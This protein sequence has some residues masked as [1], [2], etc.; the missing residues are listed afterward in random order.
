MY[1]YN[2]IQAC[3]HFCGAKQDSGVIS[4]EKS[5]HFE[6]NKDIFKSYFQK[7]MDIY[8][9]KVTDIPV[10]VFS[11][12]IIEGLYFTVSNTVVDWGGGTPSRLNCWPNNNFHAFL[13]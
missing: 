2:Y 11:Y 8:M 6:T 1:E 12:L 5:R 3:Q 4:A 7:S 13:M 10:N 9:R